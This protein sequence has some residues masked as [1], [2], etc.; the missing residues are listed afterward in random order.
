MSSG[1]PNKRLRQTQLQ[2]GPLNIPDETNC[3]G[4]DVSFSNYRPIVADYCNQQVT[5]NHGKV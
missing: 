4:T 3:Q 1:P 5:V 2:F